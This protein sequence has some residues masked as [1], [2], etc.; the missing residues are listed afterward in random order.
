MSDYQGPSEAEFR[1]EMARVDQ[2]LV[3]ARRL[4]SALVA[5]D[6]Q[7]INAV[8]VAVV[9]SGRA[10]DTLV[11][12]AFQAIDFGVALEAGGAI[13]SLQSWLDAAT[14]AQIAVADGGDAV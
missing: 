13:D 11:A 2:D 9:E 7:Q 12:M 10:I 14:F 5:G 8:L 1:H 3:Q 6:H 4:L